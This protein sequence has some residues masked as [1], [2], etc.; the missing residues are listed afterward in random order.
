MLQCSICGAAAT[1]LV[2]DC[3]DGKSAQEL[4]YCDQ[5]G[6]ELS[7]SQ[8][9]KTCDS[10]KEYLIFLRW[11]IEFV[12]TNNRM[13]T[14]DELYKLGFA[15]APAM[16]LPSNTSTGQSVDPNQLSWLKFFA[17]FL[18]E[19]ERAPTP[20][21]CIDSGLL[22]LIQPMRARSDLSRTRGAEE[23]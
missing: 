17:D 12:E 8:A 3:V 11:L 6:P 20:Q 23:T 19:H 5:H 21:E 9:L 15:E 13:P 2:T 7:G 1:V 16:Q 10:L 14:P 18:E 22:N 4:A